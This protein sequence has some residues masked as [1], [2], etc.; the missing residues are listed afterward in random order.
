MC[1]DI[2]NRALGPLPPAL[3]FKGQLYPP[4]P[5]QPIPVTCAGNGAPSV[6]ASQVSLTWS[7]ALQED[8]RFLAQNNVMDYSLLLIMYRTGPA[9]VSIIDY[10]QVPP[11]PVRTSR[12]W[13]RQ[14]HG[15]GVCASGCPRSTARATARLWGSRP[16]E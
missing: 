7:A 3:P 4:Q 11:P 6:T 8:S 2:R 14:T 10:L 13:S 1:S 12:C 9:S 16:P 15:L 5:P